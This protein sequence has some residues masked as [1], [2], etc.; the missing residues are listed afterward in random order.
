M[1]PEFS[2]LASLPEPLSIQN[3]KQ[4]FPIAFSIIPS[5]VGPC[6]IHEK[7]EVWSHG[8]KQD[9]G[10]YSVFKNLWLYTGRLQVMDELVNGTSDLFVIQFTSKI[11]NWHTDRKPT[12]ALFIVG[13]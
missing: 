2:S 9:G 6:N 3:F 10:N 4:N 13:I 8:A 11:M 7:K 1:R 5:P 12:K